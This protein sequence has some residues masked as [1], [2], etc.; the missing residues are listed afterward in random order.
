MGGEGAGGLGVD[1]GVCVCVC[2]GFV[3]PVGCVLCMCVWGGRVCLEGIW[4]RRCVGVGGG[5]KAVA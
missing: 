2:M 3:G 5:G 1:V 4:W